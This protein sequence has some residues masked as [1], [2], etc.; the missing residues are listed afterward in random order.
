MI[1]STSLTPR[2]ARAFGDR[3]AL[4]SPRAGLCVIL[5]SLRHCFSDL[6]RRHHRPAIPRTHPSN[7]FSCRDSSLFMT[8]LLRV[9][10]IAITRGAVHELG[11]AGAVDFPGLVESSGLVVGCVDPGQRREYRDLVLAVPSAPTAGR[12]FR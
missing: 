10:E 5:G 12:Q 6:F 7:A 9:N 11:M 2:S 4:R 3:F 1:R 8:E